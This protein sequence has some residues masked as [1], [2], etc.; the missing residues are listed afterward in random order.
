MITDFQ[1]TA[2]ILD[3][4]NSL[5]ANIQ[6][7][8]TNVVA[9]AR[10]VNF[11]LSLS[12]NDLNSLLEHPEIARMDGVYTYVHLLDKIQVECRSKQGKAQG[13]KGE[14]VCDTPSFSVGS[15]ICA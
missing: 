14:G 10:L 2:G 11:V 9:H 8:P 15:P 1:R 3:R 12:L 13:S 7:R 4:L 6:S 5:C